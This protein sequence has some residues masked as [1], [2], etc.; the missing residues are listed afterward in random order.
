MVK[1]LARRLS[2]TRASPLVRVTGEA[3]VAVEGV[4]VEG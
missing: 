1:Y 2:V 4:D 3:H